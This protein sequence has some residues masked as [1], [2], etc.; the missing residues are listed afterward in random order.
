[1]CLHF[2]QLLTNPATNVS[3]SLDNTSILHCNIS[4]NFLLISAHKYQAV[5]E[6][7]QRAATKVSNRLVKFPVYADFGLYMC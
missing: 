3:Y 2:S 5:K 4:G 1:M 7:T 6:R